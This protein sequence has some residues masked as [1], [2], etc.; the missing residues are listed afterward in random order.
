[1]QS[2]GTPADAT[3]AEPL[4]HQPSMPVCHSL[5]VQQL[6][7]R[8]GSQLRAPALLLLLT[9]AF[10]D[11]AAAAAAAGFFLFL[12]LAYWFYYHPPTPLAVTAEHL[13][14]IWH[15]LAADVQGLHLGD[16]AHALTHS[17]TDSVAHLEDRLTHALSDN[18]HSIQDSF[19][20]NPFLHK[21]SDGMHSVGHSLQ[22]GLHSLQHGLHA[23]ESQLQSKA[24]HLG[25]NW[26]VKASGWQAAL[27]QQLQPVVQWPTPRWPVGG[28]CCF[29]KQ[30]LCSLLLVRGGAQSVGLKQLPRILSLRSAVRS[31]T[32]ASGRSAVG[33][34]C[35]VTLCLTQLQGAACPTLLGR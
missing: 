26:A 19:Q 20:H 28:V 34:S 7:S 3:P 23:V 9:R 14:G 10:A 18:L 32:N 27:K 16:K 6:L 15:E 24:A 22:D 35:D 31:H 5:C 25:S 17:L 21:V 11:C 29:L 4:W 30:S 2:H 8:S 13:E 12:G 1:M 33:E